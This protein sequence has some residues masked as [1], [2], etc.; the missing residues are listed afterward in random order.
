M[1]LNERGY[2]KWENNERDYNYKPGGNF[3]PKNQNLSQLILLLLSRTLIWRRRNFE[4]VGETIVCD[5]SNESYWA[6]LSCGLLVS[7][8]FF[9]TKVYIFLLFSIWTWPLLASSKRVLRLRLRIET[10]F[11]SI[12][13][14]LSRCDLVVMGLLIHIPL[15]FDSSFN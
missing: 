2:I 6:V 8:R 9:K 7:W 4:S 3:T 12:V 15:N 14:I 1:C 10:N 13:R 5:H 11:L